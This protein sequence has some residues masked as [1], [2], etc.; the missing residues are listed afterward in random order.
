MK[1]FYVVCFLRFFNVR[2][3]FAYLKKYYL[4]NYMKKNNFKSIKKQQNE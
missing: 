2:A 4:C 3:I 1:A